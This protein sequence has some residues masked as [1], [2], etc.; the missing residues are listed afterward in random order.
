MIDTTV[1]EGRTITPATIP[2]RVTV[3]GEADWSVNLEPFRARLNALK[4]ERTHEF[5]GTVPA[6]LAEPDLRLNWEIGWRRTFSEGSFE[7]DISLSGSYF[8]SYDSYSPQGW[9]SIGGA[10]PLD[11]RFTMRIRNF[12][13]YWGL[14]NWNS[15]QYDLAPGY[16]MMHKEEYWGIHWL[17]FD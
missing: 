8:G 14:H 2:R 10:Y 13:L 3:G 15:Y 17:L 5:V 16:R 6:I 11:L 1:V 9:Q 4:F 12:T 7:A